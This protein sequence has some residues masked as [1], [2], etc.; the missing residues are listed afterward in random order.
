MAR[1]ARATTEPI[2][3]AVMDINT[4]PRVLLAE[5]E[6][7]TSIIHTPHANDFWKASSIEAEF[8]RQKHSAEDGDKTP[9]AWFWL[10]GYLGGKALHAH[11]SG[12]LEKAEHHIITTTAALANWHLAMFGNADMRP[13]I[14]HPINMEQPA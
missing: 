11:A 7:L 1:H 6:R 13:G 8:Q 10:V 14:A 12:N 9:A 5:I 4:D 2:G 3:V